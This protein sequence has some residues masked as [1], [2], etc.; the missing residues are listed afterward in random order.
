MQET[1]SNAL[2]LALHI[3]I[4]RNRRKSYVEVVF[5][6]HF[7]RFEFHLAPLNSSQ[8]QGFQARKR[9]IFR[10][11]LPKFSLEITHVQSQKRDFSIMNRCRKKIRFSAVEK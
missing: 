9:H 5:F 8:M 2:A 6:V 11:N 1:V 7:D 4:R 10:E 3:K